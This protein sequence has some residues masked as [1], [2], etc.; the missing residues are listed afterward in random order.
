[1]VVASDCSNEALV[2]ETPALLISATESAGSA[3]SADLG[4]G[5]EISLAMAGPAF[6]EGG[7]EVGRGVLLIP[8][9]LVVGLEMAGAKMAY[10]SAQLHS[11][12][13]SLRCR[14]EDKHWACMALLQLPSS[15][16]P[17]FETRSDQVASPWQSSICPAHLEACCS[18]AQN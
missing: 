3:G 6:P 11:W 9:P 8:F 17:H 18:S 1:V 7:V 12:I 14:H 10:G 15:S 4:V 2:G 13:Q 16:N 5:V